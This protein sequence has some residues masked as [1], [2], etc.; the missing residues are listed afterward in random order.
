[1]E[2]H[3]VVQ[4]GLKLLSSSD[5]LALASQIA[6]ITGRSH[7][8]WLS[9]SVTQAGVQWHDVGSLQTLPPGFKQFFCLSLP[10]MGFHRV[11]Q[12]G[13]KLLSSGNPPTLASQ[14]ARIIGVS[15]RAWPLPSLKGEQGV[16]WRTA[17]P[18]APPQALLFPREWSLGRRE[19]V[20]GSGYQ[21]EMG[22]QST[23][24]DSMVPLRASGVDPGQGAGDSKALCLQLLHPTAPWSM[25]TTQLCLVKFHIVTQAGVQWHILGSLQPLPP[26]FKQFLYLSLP[27]IAMRFHHVGQADLKLLASS[28][29]PAL[30]SRRAG[31]I[32]MSFRTQPNFVFSECYE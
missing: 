17:P 19:L 27:S 9:C 20:L 8:T 3:Y 16:P 22:Q 29:L 32:G 6:K 11:A 31:I 7:C 18:P 21:L 12:A 5:S 15:P 30:D 28:N 4:A 25:S 26:G 10:K 14:G 23:C 24:Q 1:M 2:F 13:L